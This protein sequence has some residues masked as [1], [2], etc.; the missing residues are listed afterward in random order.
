MTP[1]ERMERSNSFWQG[2]VIGAF[3][4]VGFIVLAIKVMMAE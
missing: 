3:V 4:S 2:Y 1:L